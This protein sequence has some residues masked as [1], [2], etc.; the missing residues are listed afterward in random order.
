M[1][2]TAL[3]V[4]DVFAAAGG[5]RGELQLLVLSSETDLKARPAPTEEQKAEARVKPDALTP[6]RQ[7]GGE[8]GGRGGTV[9]GRR[10]VFFEFVFSVE[11]LQTF[12]FECH[13]VCSTCSTLTQGPPNRASRGA[14]A[15]SRTTR[16]TLLRSRV[17]RGGGGIILM[18]V[19][20]G[21]SKEARVV[22]RTIQRTLLLSRCLAA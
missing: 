17:R 20:E 14:R 10:C 13:V 21:T 6:V 22:W 11:Q 1:Q 19:C 18:C 16:R 4:G 3:S 2:V 9:M 12:E 15:V 5:A 7:A 8:G